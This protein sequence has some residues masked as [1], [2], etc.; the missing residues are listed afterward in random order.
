[1]TLK[2]LECDEKNKLSSAR[3]VDAYNIEGASSS[4]STINFYGTSNSLKAKQLPSLK[5]DHQGTNFSN[6]F[7]LGYTA[8]RDDR[9]PYNNSKFPKVKIEEIQKYPFWV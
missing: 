7:V 3:Y 8:V 9:N 6:S 2:H 5:W 1:M 4:P